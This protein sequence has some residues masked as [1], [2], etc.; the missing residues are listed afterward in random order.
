MTDSHTTS[1]R[2]AAPFG[3]GAANRKPGINGSF[4]WACTTHSMQWRKE[5]L[6]LSTN[7]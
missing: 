6:G 3:C 4:L 5:I 2:R 1:T 7:K